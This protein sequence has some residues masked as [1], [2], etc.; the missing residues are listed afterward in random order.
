MNSM[1]TQEHQ[2]KKKRCQVWRDT[3]TPEQPIRAQ[4]KSGKNLKECHKYLH[5]I[6]RDFIQSTNYSKRIFDFL[7]WQ[8]T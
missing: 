3:G 6:Y 2:K 1:R 4:E 5:K 8:N 7:I